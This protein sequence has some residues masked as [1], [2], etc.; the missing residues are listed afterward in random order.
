V[1]PAWLRFDSPGL[2]RRTFAVGVGVV[3]LAAVVHVL[4]YFPRAVD[5]AY[6]FFRYAENLALGEGPVYNPGERVEGY[7]SPLWVLLL[8]V[9]KLL[10]AGTVTW[11]KLLALGSLA[12]LFLGVWSFGRE[13]LQLS[14]PAGL[15][16][17]LSVALDSYLISWGVWGLETPAYLALMLWTAVLLGRVAE[18]PSRRGSIAL[19]SIGGAFALARP[20]APLFL[21]ALG[22]AAVAEPLRLRPSWER[23]R[24]LWLPA[25][26][27]V[28]VFVAYLAFRRLYFG[29]WFPNTYY[30]KQGSGFLV[31]NLRP[32]WSQG[33]SVPELVFLWGGLAGTLALAAVR[34]SAAPLLASGATLVFTASVFLDWMPNVRHLLPLYVFLPLVW[35]WA[36]DRA[37]TLHWPRRTGWRGRTLGVVLAAAAV[38]VVLATSIAIARVDSR[39]S[40][41]DFMTH[42]RR[43]EWI[44]P[45][46]TAKWR[47]AWLCLTRR[48]PRHV[49]EMDSF[50]MGMITQLYRLLEADARPLEE[51]WYV[52]R[53]IGR[54]GWMAPARIFDTE[55]LFTRPVVTDPGWR[56]DRSVGPELIRAAMSR[57]VVMTELIA[58]WDAAARS[59]PEVRA[60]YEPWYPGDWG[61]LVARGREPP[62]PRQ[63]LERYEWAVDRMPD[64]FYAMT[65]YGEAV[66]AAVERR[67]DLV[68]AA[69]AD[70]PTPIART[71]PEGLEGGGVRLENLAEF[72]GCEVDPEAVAPGEELT[73]ACYYRVLSRT[74][75]RYRIFLHLEGQGVPL[76]FIADHEPVG[77]L[78]TTDHWRPGEVVRDAVR[79]RIPGDARAA[80]VRVFVGLFDG[81]RRVRA[82]PTER[83]DAVGRARGP[84]FRIERR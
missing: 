54:V 53:D 61:L 8:A 42:G 62:T 3:V 38:A 80:T 49:R 50:D 39:Y 18:H 37:A 15:L 21:A 26:A 79:V 67:R 13:R 63:I 69:V 81:E 9:G 31:S 32:L 28:A 33:A 29:L 24:R 44:L 14:R 48:V 12:A 78:L 35:A 65:I 71:V 36:A 25:A 60:S 7:S 64:W 76:R 82:T 40:P 70:N 41:M 66:G 4:Y 22:L 30:A 74:S 5:D 20:E 47:D 43:H 1:L 51:T 58:E 11:C 72:L 23:V 56:T 73:V 57:A 68:R 45:K 2:R 27:A 77:G 84:T 55:G 52:G 10:G 19:A 34:R 46:T 16:A 83:V 59:S 6:I 17:C 75:Q